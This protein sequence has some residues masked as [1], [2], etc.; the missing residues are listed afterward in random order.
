LQR[1][2][3]AMKW[4]AIATLVLATSVSA[5]GASLA[6]C[7]LVLGPMAEAK[8]DAAV[9]EAWD[10]CPCDWAAADQSATI[11]ATA[12]N[13]FHTCVRL[14]ARQAIIDRVLPKECYATVGRSAK[15][16]TCGYHGAV[17]CCLSHGRCV[18][19]KPKVAGSCLGGGALPVGAVCSQGGDCCSF[20]CANIDPNTGHGTCGV[21][22]VTT[23][24]TLPP[25]DPT[26][27]C[28]AQTGAA[29]GQSISCYDA[30]PPPGKVACVLDANFDAMMDA[31]EAAAK[32][33]IAAVQGNPYDGKDPQQVGLFLTQTNHELPCF[34][35]G[36]ATHDYGPPEPPAASLATPLPAA[37]TEAASIGQGDFGCMATFNDKERKYCGLGSSQRSPW[38]AP[39][40][41]NVLRFL[42]DFRCN[43][44]LNH[45][46]WAH[47]G[48][49]GY[50]CTRAPCM[51][52]NPPSVFDPNPTS[53]DTCTQ[54]FFRDVYNCAQAAA[55]AGNFSDARCIRRIRDAAHE[56]PAAWGVVS[57]ISGHCDNAFER[58]SCPQPF[59]PQFTAPG[60]Y[61]TCQSFCE[62][63]GELGD[64]LAA[65]ALCCPPQ[66]P[67]DCF[68]NFDCDTFNGQ[69]CDASTHMCAPYPF[70]PDNA[71]EPDCAKSDGFH[72]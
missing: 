23:T 6:R 16:S 4:L 33:T 1:K 44:C 25:D 50:M 62:G 11:A 46:C 14:H 61:C 19:S 35:P 65:G 34:A 40:P 41:M 54:N 12:R 53:G 63:C 59:P 72:S 9:A 70:C 48:C 58:T 2:G 30:C 17:T 51:F 60:Q 24:T 13:A 69:H 18:V 56:V 45:A 55:L 57:G 8:L 29:L 22:V 32:A 39:T 64:K 10:A 20:N 71:C 27:R 67:T 26:A 21:Q 38:I 66:D 42:T 3:C 52:A 68:F 7:L 49:T 28:L 5:Q 15:D 36:L 43:A 37:L 31:A 47:D